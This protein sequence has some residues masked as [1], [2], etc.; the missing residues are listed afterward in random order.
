MSSH[1]DLAAPDFDHEKRV[2][3]PFSRL[4]YKVRSNSRDSTST[5]RPVCE[6]E[7]NNYCVHKKHREGKP[8]RRREVEKKVQMMSNVHSLRMKIPNFLM[9]M[10]S[11]THAA[12]ISGSPPG[13]EP[14]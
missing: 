14:M 5:R 10:S 2:G 6:D 12:S 11:K 7:S 4:R 9:S 3:Y 1:E 13:M 8:S